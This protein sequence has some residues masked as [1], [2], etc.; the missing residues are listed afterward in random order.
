MNTEAR[1]TPG[2]WDIFPHMDGTADIGHLESHSNLVRFVVNLPHHSP[3]EQANAKL[4]TAAPSLLQV[5]EDF[6]SEA[7][8]CLNMGK[9]TEWAYAQLDAWH[10]KRKAAIAKALGTGQGKA[11]STKE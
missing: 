8:L 3:N 6:P 7:I 2:P 11:L 5:A 10:E 4:I 9:D 1:H